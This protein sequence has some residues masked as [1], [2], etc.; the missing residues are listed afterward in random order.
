MNF[1]IFKKKPV[2][3]KAKKKGF[4]REWLD[5]GVFAVV[6]ATLIRTFIMEAYTIPTGSMEGSLLI[7]DFL[8]VSKMHYG[9]RIP[10]TPLAVPFIHNEMP[11]GGKSYSEAVQWGYHRLPGFQKISR[12]DDVVFNYPEGDTV[13]PDYPGASYYDA[14]RQNPGAVAQLN[15]DRR[16]VDKMDNYIKRC[17]GLPGDKIE[18]RE[19]KLFVNDATSPDFRFLQSSYFV[20]VKTGQNLD[21]DALEEMDIQHGENNNDIFERGGGIYEV[22]TNKESYGKIKAM[23][24]VDS[25]FEILYPAGKVM[26]VQEECFPHDPQYP[27]NRDNFGPIVLP[28]KGDVVQINLQTLPLY[29]RLIQ[30]Y[31]KHDLQVADSTIKIDGKVATS[32]TIEGN[33]F[34]MMGDNRHNSLDSRFW[35]YVPETHVVGKA[36]FVW[37]SYNGSIAHPRFGRMFRGIKNLEK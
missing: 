5:A 18:V 11:G 26:G 27:Y 9:A 3:P 32:Y 29:R 15:I 28:K 20:K 33:Y 16:P 6:V 35:G 22:I 21:F 31:E 4:L 8:F 19:G 2:D 23:P 36:W 25:S 24:W 34:W 10:M 13:M 1:N 12:Y 7:N 30:V 37:F 14:K 17:V